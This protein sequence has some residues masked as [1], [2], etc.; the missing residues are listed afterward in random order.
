MGYYFIS[1]NRQSQPIAKDLAEDIGNLGC[2][3]WL[4]EALT[5]GR[6]WWD[7]IL[8]KIR[9]CDVFVFVLDPAALESQACTREYS[10]AAGLGK[11]ILPVLVSEGV[12]TDLLP[13]ALSQIQ[14]VD[15][16]SRDRTAAFHLARAIAS[17][18]AAPPLPDPLPPPPQVPS[19]IWGL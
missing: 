18:P 15:Y 13:S 7:Q 14:F 10:Y 6:T 17:V 5:G 2:A 19:R 1:Y 3:V 8:A 4:D 12:S 11:P 9:G 16:R